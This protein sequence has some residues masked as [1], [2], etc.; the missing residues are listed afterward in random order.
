MAIEI[1]IADYQDQAQAKDIVELLYRYSIDPMGGGKALSQ[2]VQDNLVEQL[3]ARSDATTILA[4]VDGQAAGLAN[5]FEGFST[6]NCKPLINIHDVIVLSQFRGQG[7]SQRLLAEV[8]AFARREGCCKVTLEVLQGNHIAQQAYQKCG[9]SAYELDPTL[10][11]A[12][13]WEKSLL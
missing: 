6:F 10:G 12:M 5:C 4:Y 13:F 7:L 9:F 3:A 11:Q 8:E 1:C 2:F